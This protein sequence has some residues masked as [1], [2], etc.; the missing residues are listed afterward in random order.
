MSAVIAN[1]KPETPRRNG[2]GSRHS[3]RQFDG[4]A[5]GVFLDGGQS[6]SRRH[7]LRCLRSCTGSAK[8]TETVSVKGV[9]HYAR[10]FADVESSVVGD[11][12]AHQG[13]CQQPTKLSFPISFL[14]HPPT[15]EQSIRNG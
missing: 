3:I 2:P 11:G 5:R 12:V 6:A 7:R 10:V 13:S 8:Q 1:A 15:A 4:N 9:S 14:G